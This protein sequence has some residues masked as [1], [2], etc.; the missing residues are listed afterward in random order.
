MIQK[1]YVSKFKKKNPKANK[2]N[3]K[4]NAERK[5]CTGQVLQDCLTH[6]IK[7]VLERKGKTYN[8]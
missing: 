7:T 3:R 8:T 4:A 2:K 1:L 5:T 6:V